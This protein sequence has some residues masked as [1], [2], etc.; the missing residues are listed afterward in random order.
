[1]SS[2]RRQSGTSCSSGPIA[3]WDR[4]C[5]S[6]SLT[7]VWAAGARQCVHAHRHASLRTLG[8]EWRDKGPFEIAAEL[9]RRILAHPEGVEIARQRP[10]TNFE[11]HL[12][13]DDKQ[14]PPRAAADAGRDRARR[15]D[16][17]A[18]RSATIPSFSPPA[19]AP[20]WTANTIQRDPAWRKGPRPALRPQPVARATPTALGIA[21]GDRVRV[22]TRR[23]AVELPAA[24][25]KRLQPGHVWV[26]NG[27]GTR[28]PRGG[29]GELETAG[30]NLNLLSA[31]EDRDPFTGCPHHKYT[32]CRI[33]R[34]E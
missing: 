10:E 23:G 1:M 24:V 33:E 28:Y 29:S 27:F 30:V 19:C 34:C 6:P 16:R 7:A 15:R 12:G 22:I 17:P 11:D 18:E 9:F 26:P 4:I 25:D 2:R 21:D 14:G 31:S 5:P 20:R 32:L 3:P 8:A 13:F